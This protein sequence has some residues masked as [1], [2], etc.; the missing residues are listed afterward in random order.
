MS[1]KGLPHVISDFKRL[2]PDRRPNPDIPV[3]RLHSRR[4]P[5]GQLSEARLDNPLAKPTP[6]RMQRSALARGWSGHE[7]REAVGRHDQAGLPRLSCA[8]AVGVTIARD[9]VLR[10]GHI[11]A[12][13]L[14]QPRYGLGT[15]GGQPLPVG[16][17]GMGVIA[18]MV[19]YVEA[20][21][22]PFGGAPRPIGLQRNK[23][24][25]E[26]SNHLVNPGGE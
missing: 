1:K 25:G 2:K 21:V 8:G 11:N 24:L 23:C 13:D 12:M 19:A 26:K 16:G 5:M 14:A 6:T 3:I 4:R 7:D 20:C 9:G 22:R 17:D 18:N 15:E 10:A